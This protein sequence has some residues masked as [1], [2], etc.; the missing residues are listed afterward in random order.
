MLDRAAIKIIAIGGGFLVTALGIEHLLKKKVFISFAVEDRDI[1]DLMVGQSKNC[2]T[3]FE[4]T[5]RSVKTPYE[6]A[7]KTQCRKRIR[8]CHGIIVLVSENIYQADGVHWEIK[9]AKEE[10]I[11]IRA[12]YARKSSKGCR[13]PVGLKGKHIYKWTWENINNFVNEL[14]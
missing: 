6:N 5:D 3:P 2:K 1:R 11:P 9:C 4:F 12:I 13:I 8:A 14:K 7:W 10:G